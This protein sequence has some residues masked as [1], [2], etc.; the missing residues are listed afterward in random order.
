MKTITEQIVEH[1]EQLANEWSD[2]AM[3]GIVYGSKGSTDIPR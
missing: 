1:L 3:R 2:P